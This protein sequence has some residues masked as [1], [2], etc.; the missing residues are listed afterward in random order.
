MT[1]SDQ[2]RWSR[3]QRGVRTRGRR[4]GL[5]MPLLCRL[6]VALSICASAPAVEFWNGAISY[7]PPFHVLTKPAQD[8]FWGG[9]SGYFADLDGYY[10]EV[11]WAPMCT[12]DQTG[13]I[14]FK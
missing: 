12:F 4:F 10:W 14:V 5:L 1:S 11:A 2:F 8:V 7:D 3:S 9:H 6:A 13:A